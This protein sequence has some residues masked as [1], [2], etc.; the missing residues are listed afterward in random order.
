MGEITWEG[1]KPFGLCFPAPCK[2]ENSNEKPGPECACAYGYK[3]KGP[4]VQTFL[5]SLHGV[6]VAIPCEGERSNHQ[7]GP[8]C[9]CADGYNGTV[10]LGTIVKNVPAARNIT[11]F[12]TD[13]C[14]P[15]KCAVENTIGDGKECRCQ[16]GYQGSVTWMGPD[17]VGACKPAHCSI[18]NS[19]RKPGLECRCLDGYSGSISTDVESHFWES[20]PDMNEMN[21]RMLSPGG[22]GTG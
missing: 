18:E 5:K 2:F 10:Q 22:E 6:C 3:G 9:R 15:A 20:L 16:D 7:D 4:V 17:A 13:S 21:G 1:V 8:G 19:N 12:K 14:V 11:V